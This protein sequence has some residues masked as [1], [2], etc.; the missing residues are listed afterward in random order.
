MTFSARQVAWLGILLAVSGQAG[1]PAETG[2]HPVKVQLLAINDLHGHLEAVDGP[3]GSVN[4]VPAGGTEYLAT[5][6]RNAIKANR[7]SIF[8]GAGDMM[9]ASP[10]LSATFADKPMVKA[11]NAMKMG[12]TAIGNHELDNGPA[13]FLRRTRSA[14]YTYLAANMIDSATR[15]PLLPGTKIVTIG[16]VKV[17][18]IGET[19]QGTDKMLQ[20]KAT[21]GVSFLEESAVA[22]A[23]AA[24]LEARGVRAIVL[25]IHQGGQQN[26]EKGGL[27]DP[28]GCTSLSG[29]I[30][31]IVEKLAPSIKVVVSAHS[32]NFYN[33]EIRGHRL[34]SA[35]SFGR[36]YT[37]IGLSIDPKSGEIVGVDARNIIATHDVVRD[38][39]QTAIIARY[40]PAVDRMAARVVGSASGFLDRINNEA[41]ESTLGD[42]VAD[43]TLFAA[44]QSHHAR[45]G[46][47]NSGGIRATITMPAG[48]A[49]RDVTF[50]DLYAIQPFANHVSVVTLTGDEIRQLLE[51][52][53]RTEGQYTRFL[54]VSHGFTYSYRANAPHGGHIVPGSVKLDG[55]PIASDEPII[56]ATSD[57]LV[58]GGDGFTI[59]GKG[60]DPGVVAL[61]ID[62]LVHYFETHSPVAPGPQDRITK[63]D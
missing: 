21:K 46:F 52:Q 2:N 58:S 40:K 50:G 13:E 41:G 32:H 1:Q 31:G 26:V 20:P 54:Q 24:K 22:N 45:I 4:R 61:D 47:V 35:G 3:D 42:V 16:G 56:V 29:D 33:C 23:E 30:V 5:H 19:L 55:R 7:Y 51:E 44:A 14:R 38:P 60:R 53:F 28:N 11:L 18:F 57:F 34:T 15:K 37:N 59:F 25:L 6:L 49:K 36:L 39:K 27:V 43:A 17:G 10:L 62:A 8:I 63:V 12:V 9:G 48:A